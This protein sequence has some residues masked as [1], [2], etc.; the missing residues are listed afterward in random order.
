MMFFLRKFWMFDRE[1]RT[2]LS[3]F[4]LKAWIAVEISSFTTA[5]LL[6]KP[7]FA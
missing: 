2:Q 4:M 6:G 7:I 5:R 3:P 1:P